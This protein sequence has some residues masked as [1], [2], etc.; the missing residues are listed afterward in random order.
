MPKPLLRRL[1][2]LLTA[3]LL[4]AAIA[5][6]DDS[7]GGGDDANN[8]VL[9]N[10]D[11]ANNDTANNDD[12]A[13]N[14]SNNDDDTSNNDEPQGVIT[15]Q[16]LVPEGAKPEDAVRLI[17]LGDSISA[18]V[19]SSNRSLAYFRLLEDNADATYA[20]EVETDLTSLFG[21]EVE[22]VNEAIGGATSTTMRSGQVPNLRN[23]L[24][25][26]VAGHSVV[27][28]TIGGN[29]L[30]T[31]FAAGADLQGDYLDQ[32]I[33]NIRDVIEFLQD[34]E[35]FPDGTSIF[36]ANVYDPGDGVGQTPS[37]F[38]GVSL[39]A[40]S[41]ALPVWA[42]RYDDL[43]YDYNIGIVDALGAFRGHGF[44]Y[45]DPSNEH[46]DAADPTLWFESD[47]IHPNDRGHN[48]LRRVFFE[49]IAPEGAYLAD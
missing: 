1:L 18:G 6:G 30:T 8:D 16:N 9:A 24:G 35:L 28:I 26:P 41:D 45:N 37:C 48:E 25:G 4:S 17:V 11:A 39:Q 5:C 13:N 34:P 43:A 47:C 38:G 19:G 33:A 3:A 2:V 27:V 49:A 14:T 29:D 15:H 36:L 44:Y 10:N 32:V 7:S 31:G 46:Y 12:A 23:R 21:H 20:S 40:A 42:R 22:L